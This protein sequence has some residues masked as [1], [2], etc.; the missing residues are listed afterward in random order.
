MKNF[1]NF[2]GY[3]T[4]GHPAIKSRFRNGEEREKRRLKEGAKE[5][6]EK[7]GWKYHRMRGDVIRGRG[8]NEGKRREDREGNSLKKCS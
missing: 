4:P 5:M 3:N 7:E 8:G 6:K 1:T 2:P